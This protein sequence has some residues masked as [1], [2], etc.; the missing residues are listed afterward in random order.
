[1]ELQS[2]IHSPA[3]SPMTDLSALPAGRGQQ[4]I[5]KV[6]ADFESV[7]I[8]VLFKEMRKTLE[9]GSLF[10]GDTSDIYGSM[11]DTF[12]AQHMAQQGSAL[13]IG[14]MVRSYLDTEQ[15]AAEQTAARQTPAAQQPAVPQPATVRTDDHATEKSR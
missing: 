12:M 4:D 10:P 8:S 11:F 14:D 9:E 13:G 7:F 1:M 3:L 15:A 5:E 6:A 2:P